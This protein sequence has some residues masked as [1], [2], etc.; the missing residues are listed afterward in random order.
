MLS[1]SW[2]TLRGG[3]FEGPKKERKKIKKNLVFGFQRVFARSKLLWTARGVRWSFWLPK[4]VPVVLILAEVMNIMRA[5]Y[6]L[7]VAEPHGHVA[8]TCALV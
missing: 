7:I 3:I 1:F 5:G 8:Y 6:L 2:M 4:E